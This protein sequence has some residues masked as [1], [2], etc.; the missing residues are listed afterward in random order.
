MRHAPSGPTLNQ[1]LIISHRKDE[2]VHR[3]ALI[4][5]RGE[6]LERERESS[7][8]LYTGYPLSIA[9]IKRETGRERASYQLHKVKP[10]TFRDLQNAN[11]KRK[12]NRIRYNQDLNARC[13]IKSKNKNNQWYKFKN[14]RPEMIFSLGRVIRWY[15]NYFSTAKFNIFSHLIQLFAKKATFL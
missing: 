9:K 4:A 10:R 6:L 8:I 12:G 13:Y 2:N 11:L 15:Q 14:I 1:S 5:L 3:F 7:R